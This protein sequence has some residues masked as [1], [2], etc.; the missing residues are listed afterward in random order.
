QFVPSNKWE[1]TTLEEYIGGKRTSTISKH[2]AQ[3]QLET[4]SLS[5]IETKYAQALNQYFRSAQTISEQRYQK[6]S[7]EIAAFDA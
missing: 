7:A 5:F 3:G 1:I 6:N 4:L 2:L